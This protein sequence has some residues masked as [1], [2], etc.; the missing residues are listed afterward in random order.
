MTNKT[1][2]NISRALTWTVGIIFGIIVVGL[3]VGYYLISYENTAGSLEALAEDLASELSQVIT[4]NPDA[5]EYQQIRYMGYL[6]QRTWRGHEE[7]RRIFNNKGQVVA[8]HAD[9]LSAPLIMR[10]AELYD[11]GIVVGRIEISRSMQPILKRAALFTLLV[12]PLSMGVF[13][14]MHKLPL[15]AIKVSEQSLRESEAR[16]RKL[17]QEFHTLLNATTDALLLVSRDLTVIWA[18]KG[19]SSLFSQGKDPDLTGRHCYELLHQSS[20]PC[21]ECFIRNV[22]TSGNPG[23]SSYSVPGGKLLE[24][25]AFPIREEDGEIRNVLAMVTDVTEKTVL[26][27]EA[28][29]A[30]H[31]ASLG[32]LAAGVAHEINNPINGVINYAQLLI[33]KAPEASKENDLARRIIKEGERIA[34][35]V[36]GLLAFA[37][38]NKD[39]NFAVVLR[40]ILE[41]TVMLTA[42]QLRHDGIRVDWDVPERLEKI[43]VNPQQIQ[44]VFLNVISNARH[45]LNLKYP[46]EHKNKTLS[47][48]C[49]S[50]VTRG[51]SYVRTTFYDRGTGIPA[52]ILDKVTTPF[53]STKPS[54][55]GTG[56]GLSISH[57]IVKSHGGR[58]VIE[59]EE[60]KY[61]RVIV[62]LPVRRQGGEKA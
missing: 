24:A 19:A 16:F 6:S 48:S 31:L 61:T 49:E 35:I 9:R 1:S 58:I 53:F 5:W 41:D 20:S 11:S 38:E 12:L 42:A 54:G 45:A 27:A 51:A 15:A 37:R 62:D 44:Q 39:E 22:Y 14:L 43:V 17:S 26:Q 25:R 34:R 7:I 60:G 50:I 57:K 23:S 59:S 56:L 30:G 18:N 10:S 46:G 3:P 55:Q 33:N 32:E 40:E 52:D 2:T 13:F 36:G 47:I 8:E 29:R 4:E 28:M 21:E